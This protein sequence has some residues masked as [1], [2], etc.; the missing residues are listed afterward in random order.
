MPNVRWDNL[1]ACSGTLEELPLQVSSL[2]FWVPIDVFLHRHEDEAIPEIFR[3]SNE[4]HLHHVSDFTKELQRGVIWVDLHLLHE[5]KL[6]MAKRPNSPAGC[7]IK[8]WNGHWEIAEVDK[9]GLTGVKKWKTQQWRM[10][11][12]HDAREWKKTVKMKHSLFTRH[13][14][15]LRLNLEPHTVKYC[16]YNMCCLHHPSLTWESLLLVNENLEK[17][18]T[19]CSIAP[20]KEAAIVSQRVFKILENCTHLSCHPV[21]DHQEL[22]DDDH[23]AENCHQFIQ[24]EPWSTR[25][26]TRFS[27]HN[28][29]WSVG[30]VVAW[31]VGT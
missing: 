11:M 5:S 18:K 25:H 10:R 12:R 6:C 15:N 2:F 27:V 30:P 1:F 8:W 28:G 3:Q 4:F 20:F 19:L 26:A 31:P 9:N 21:V 13:V 14:L 17:K 29:Y 22:E 7:G 23:E 16:V 24:P